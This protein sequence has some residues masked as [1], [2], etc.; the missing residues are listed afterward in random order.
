M[1]GEREPITDAKTMWELVDRRAQSDGDRTMLID[2]RDNTMTFGQ[3][4]DEAEQVA[5]GLLSLGVKDGT[6][7]SWQLPMQVDTVVLSAALSRLG[8]VQNPIIHLY[9]E[10][11]VGFALRQTGAKFFFVP[12]TWRNFDY[13]DLGQRVTAD[14]DNPPQIV[15]IEGGLPEGDPAT[16]PPPPPL[17]PADEIPIRWIYYTSGSTADPKGVRHTDQTLITGGWGLAVSSEMTPDDVGS[18][19]FPYA[20]I[21]GPDYLVALLS[22]GFPVVLFEAFALPDVLGPMR[23]YGVTMVGGSTAFYVAFLA[24]QRKHPDEPVLP[25]RRRMSG[26]GAPKPPAIHFEVQKEI[27]GRGVVHGLGMTEVPMIA[28]GCPSDTDEQLANTDGAPIID[29]DVRIVRPDGTLADPD[30]E[31]EIRVKGPMVFRGYTDPKLTKEAFD[32]NGY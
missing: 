7:V 26:G 25:R 27:G 5:A 1:S 23:K 14:L 31:G 12:G 29:A 18:V 13:V 4:R 15:A 21:G 3:F 30:E 17:L 6:T 9:R 8:A 22:I 10:R 20:H 11:E 24:E 28:N 19:A 32:E 2:E 16:L